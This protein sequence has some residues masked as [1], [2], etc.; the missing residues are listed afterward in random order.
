[1]LALAGAR[2]GVRSACE[3]T[4]VNADKPPITPE[5]AAARLA[6]FSEDDAVWLTREARNCPAITVATALDRPPDWRRTPSP[7]RVIR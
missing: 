5:S 4:I 6:R 1:M 2:L 3:L 7:M